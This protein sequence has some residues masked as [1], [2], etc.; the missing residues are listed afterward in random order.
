M[1]TKAQTAAAKGWVQ[2]AAA[3]LGPAQRGTV[4]WYHQQALEALLGLDEDQAP[5]D[6]GDQAPAES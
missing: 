3:K 1:T 4:E 6:D 5:A 2:A